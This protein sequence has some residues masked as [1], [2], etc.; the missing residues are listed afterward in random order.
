MLPEKL[1]PEEKYNIG[2]TLKKAI[3]ELSQSD[4]RTVCLN[5]AVIFNREQESYILPYLNRKY[6]V[7]HHSG[8][9]RPFS[10]GAAAVSIHQQIL[11]LHYL[12][13]AKGTPL[14]NEWITFKELPGGQIY[15]GPYQNRTIRPLLQYFGAQPEKLPA[16]AR[17]FGGQPAAFGDHAVT[18]YP[19]P[20]VP[21]T[22]VLWAGDEEFPPSGNILYDASAAD[23]LATEDYA[24]L[25]GLIIW[26]MAAYMAQ[27]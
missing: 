7:N 1:T 17:D 19:F 13:N 5:S 22:F 14:K 18:F 8:Q 27:K 21:L 3:K 23:Y 26:E 9:V 15:V 4:P 11:F 2:V 16:T 6:L 25:P 12:I 10:E 24:L 20:R